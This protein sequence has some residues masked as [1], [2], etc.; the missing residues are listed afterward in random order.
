MRR[1][2]GVEGQRMHEAR[3]RAACVRGAGERLGVATAV[4]SDERRA[5]EGKERE[6]ESVCVC[7]R[8]MERGKGNVVI[9]SEARRR[10]NANPKW[11]L[12]TR[13]RTEVENAENIRFR[14]QRPSYPYN[15][16]RQDLRNAVK[17]MHP[18]VHLLALNWSLDQP[19]AEIHR[20]CAD[21]IMTRGTNHQT[22]HGDKQAP[23]HHVAV[24]AL[25]CHVAIVALRYRVAAVALQ[26]HVA[27]VALQYHVAA[28]ALQYRVAAVALQYRVAAVA[29][30]YRVAAVALRYHVAAVALR[31]RVAA[32]ALRYRVAAVA[33]RYHVAAVALRYHIA[34]VA[35]R[36]RVAAV[37]LRRRVAVV[38]AR[39]ELALASQR[40]WWQYRPARGEVEAAPRAWLEPRK[41][42]KTL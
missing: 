1:A 8:Q 25:R 40:W 35:L 5:S 22:L 17:G 18:P 16:H 21:H 10:E 7:T 37:A 23:R 26:Y 38:I 29:L 11:Q 36:Y 13:R 30:Q 28:V 32:V 2:R 3:E 12:A 24:V 4:H 9:D 15:V 39:L 20:I 42:E 14:G 31:Y 19:H 27:A 34:A 41:K 33:L 6:R